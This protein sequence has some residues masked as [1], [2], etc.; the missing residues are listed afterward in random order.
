MTA[1]ALDSNDRWMAAGA[2]VGWACGGP[3][4]PLVLLAVSWSKR[5]SLARRHALAATV[6]WAVALAIWLPVLTVG[7]FLRPSDPAVYAVVVAVGLG[8][9]TLGLSVAGAILALR[10]PLVAQAA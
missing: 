7:V 2:W 3:L 5:D 8:L 4:V 1:T 10:S 6:M 9:G